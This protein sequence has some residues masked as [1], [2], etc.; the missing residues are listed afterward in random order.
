M[1]KNGKIAIF[2]PTLDGGGAERAMVNLA[3]GLV[4]LGES[5]DMVLRRAQGAYLPLLDPAVRVVDLDSKRL[6]QA[7]PRLV[8]YLRKERPRAMIATMAYTNIIA[9]WAAQRARVGT[10][11]IVNEQVHMSRW[12]HGDNAPLRH[13]TLPPLIRRYYPRADA[14]VA[15]SEGVADDLGRMM[16]RTRP[17]YVIY[18]PG[19]SQQVID[20]AEQP[21]NHP[22][23]APGEPPVILAAGRLTEQK[24][25]PTLLRA[26]D[27]LRRRREARL[28]ILGEGE[29]RPELEALV[30]ELGLEPLVQMPGF[31][32]N[33]LSFMARAA[34]FALSSRYEGMG[35]VL[36][37]ALAGGTPV[38]STDCE[39][40]PYEVLEGGRY[41]W[42]VPVGD[43]QA[44]A[45]ALEE[46]LT[47][48][49]EADSLRR[50][51]RDFSPTVI[52]QQYLEVLERA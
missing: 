27:L 39:S 44:F 4:A 19:A 31:V 47:Q 34:V 24:D 42:L 41:G 9:I 49:T 13:R 18:N 26:F 50:R 37:E 48:P 45:D 30:R 12:I 29:D 6:L 43:V 16:G 23:F 8:R 3:Q 2:S 38:V 7:L 5:V 1:K 52:A 35:L 36:I 22:W 14:I 28:L 15:V 11:V 17:I 20:I 10:R 21:V 40:G 51:A 25:F 32:N 46:A 33:P